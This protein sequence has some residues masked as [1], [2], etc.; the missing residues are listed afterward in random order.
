[1]VFTG[2]CLLNFKQLFA[3]DKKMAFQP[4]SGFIS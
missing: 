4:I 2:T 1:M 3:H